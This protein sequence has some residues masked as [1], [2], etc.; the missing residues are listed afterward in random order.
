VQLVLVRWDEGA[1]ALERR[2]VADGA[3]ADAQGARLEIEVVGREGARPR[4]EYLTPPGI[5]HRKGSRARC[6]QRVERRHARA[7]DAERDREPASNGQPDTGAREAAGAGPHDESVYVVGLDTRVRQ[8]R[9]D[10]Y[11]KGARS[12]RSLAEH[13]L[14]VEERA[15]R[16]VRRCVEGQYEHLFD[17]F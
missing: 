16:D 12:P 7:G 2:S 1:H 13:T 14:T 9:V 15:R 8:E 5:D 17:A 4:N 10:V 6:G 3:R 11:E